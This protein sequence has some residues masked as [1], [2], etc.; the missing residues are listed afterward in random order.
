[1]N[2]L[3]DNTNPLLADVVKLDYG[4]MSHI[5][6]YGINHTSAFWSNEQ[7]ELAGKAL[8][9]AF[10]LDC[11]PLDN[12]SFYKESKDIIET[13]TKK[14]NNREEIKHEATLRWE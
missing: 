9:R 13:F 4:E 2:L 1:M 8:G 7:M 6:T 5:P 10:D 14:R 11:V 12:K 3:L